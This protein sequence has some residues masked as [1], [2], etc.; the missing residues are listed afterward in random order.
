MRLVVLRS[1]EIVMLRLLNGAHPNVLS[2]HDVSRMENETL[3]LIMPKMAGS[4]AGAIEKQSLGNKEKLRVAALSLHAL[5]WLHSHGIIHRDLKPDNILLDRAGDPVLADFSLAK[6]VGARAADDEADAGRRAGGRRGK[7]ARKRKRSG[8][9]G[10]AAEEAA[11]TA[12]MGT[13]TYTA[14]EI[15][16]GEPY[17]VSADVF[18]LGVVLLELFHGSGLEAWKDKHAL[19]ELEAIKAKLSDKPSA[20]TARSAH[21]TRRR[22]HSTAMGRHSTGR[23]DRA[24]PA[25]A[26]AG[27]VH[28]K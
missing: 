15:V 20:R 13:P 22:A 10:D 14:P 18:S 25:C 3:A 8:D 19:A 5:A 17:G 1:G 7:G 9:E 2:M 28:M 26:M 16:N 21:R 12:S 11:L 4:L 27:V 24:W 6:V 23:G